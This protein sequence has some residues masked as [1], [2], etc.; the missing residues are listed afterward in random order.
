VTYQLSDSA[1]ADVQAVIDHYRAA[2]RGIAIGFIEDVARCLR[3][4]SR[5]PYVGSS[6]G[7]SFRRMPLNRYPYFL[8][9]QVANNQVYVVSVYHQRRHPERWRNRV[10]ETAAVYT[11]AA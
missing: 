9:Y 10:Q 4:L 3:L 7:Q 2:S 6:I 11:L 1:V 8:I 5:N